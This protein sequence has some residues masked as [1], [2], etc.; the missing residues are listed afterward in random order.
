MSSPNFGDYL[1]AGA[2]GA[3]QGFFDNQVKENEAA[4]LKAEQERQ[5]KLLLLRDELAAKREM[6]KQKDQQAFE[7]DKLGKTQAFTAAESQKER[8]QKLVDTE[9]KNEFEMR[10]LGAESSARMKEAEKKHGYD[11]EIEGI[12]ADK[13]SEDRV[14]KART[15]LRKEFQKAVADR[16]KGPFSDQ[17]KAPLEFTSWAKEAYPEL[18]AEAFPGGPTS[19]D[20]V[21][22]DGGG[23]FDSIFNKVTGAASRTKQGAND[24]AGPAIPTRPVSNEPARSDLPP[25]S[26]PAAT[27]PTTA[28]LPSMSRAE[29][30]K[31]QAASERTGLV[32][33]AGVGEVASIAS[34]IAQG[35]VA[36][37]KKGASIVAD[38][39][40]AFVGQPT[41][42]V[43][44]WAIKSQ[45][46]QAATYLLEQRLKN[47]V[48]TAAEFDAAVSKLK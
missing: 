24:A 35:F 26:T 20:A 3:A 10:K 13:R 23:K 34:Q 22:T 38:L 27:T 11:V 40:K 47:G 16:A 33:T 4:K 44:D 32:S 2:G 30:L 14:N 1:I 17:S 29:A 37:T 7:L 19:T 36:G 42:A 8:A 5:T 6:A 9:S 39:Y 45:N 41:E 25:V 18:Y 46:E 15:E 21:P 43:I 31:Q 48:I 28:D 12:R